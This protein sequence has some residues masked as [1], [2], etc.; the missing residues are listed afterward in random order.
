MAIVFMLSGS[1]TLSRVGTANVAMLTEARWA[2]D[3]IVRETKYANSAQVVTTGM[4]S[5]ALDNTLILTFIDPFDRKIT[6][7]SYY[8]KEDRVLYRKSGTSGERPLTNPNQAGF[9]KVM[10]NGTSTLPLGFTLTGRELRIQCMV[11]SRNSNNQ[12]Q[13]ERLDTTVY[14]LNQ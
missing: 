3:T 9:E 2:L 13:T 4:P 1:L 8:Y 11:T 12:I 6:T 7:T 14:L 5:G 10:I